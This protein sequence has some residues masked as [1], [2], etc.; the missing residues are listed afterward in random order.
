MAAPNAQ[1]SGSRPGPAA[2]HTHAPNQSGKPSPGFD[3]A[4][5]APQGVAPHGTPGKVGANKKNS[6]R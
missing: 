1:P 2:A 3:P 4:N 5:K 6:L